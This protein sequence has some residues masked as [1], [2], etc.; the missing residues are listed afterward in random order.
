[1]WEWVHAAVPNTTSAGKF[2]AAAGK[3]RACSSLQAGSR[4]AAGTFLGLQLTSSGPED[5]TESIKTNIHEKYTM[6]IRPR[7][8]TSFIQ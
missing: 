1:V 7:R 5:N 6:V 2:G 4:A 3:F 8:N